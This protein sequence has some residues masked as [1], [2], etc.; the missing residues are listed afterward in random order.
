MNK[1]HKTTI[2]GQAVIEGVMMRGPEKSML[3]VRSTDGKI[4]AEELKGGT[5]KRKGFLNLPF[6]RGV[7][8]FAD[9]MIF[10]YKTLSQS[11]DISLQEADKDDGGVSREDAQPQELSEENPGSSDKPDQIQEHNTT[12]EAAACAAELDDNE[13]KQAKSQKNKKESKSASSQIMLYFSLFLGAA[14]AIGLFIILPSVCT[15][16]ISELFKVEFPRWR[17][18]VEG[19]IRLVIFLL[20]LLLVCQMKDIK[21]VFQYHG[22]E[23][24][25][26]HCYES[27][28]DITVENV[29]KQK[30]SH[31][32]CGTSFLLIVM[33][34]SVLVF[35]LPIFPWDKLWLR[36]LIKLPFLPVIAGISYEIIRFAGRHDNIFTR[37]IS[38]PGM[39]L[40]YLTTREPDDLQIEVAIAALVPCIPENKDDDKW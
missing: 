36:W 35:M 24:K 4:I 5:K 22:A 30:R 23:H 38:A 28:L 8:G 1:P 33:I 20:Y 11:A 37:I 17:T 14:L 2:G 6:V 32:R 25:S 3:A 40:Q 16:G 13:S 12:S 34:V 27:G 10:G 39:L 7:V 26:I 18:A 21:R 29:K 31:P 19:I 15:V 9:S